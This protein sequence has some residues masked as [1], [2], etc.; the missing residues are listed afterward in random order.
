[1]DQKLW[2]KVVAFHGHECP[3]LAIGFRACEAAAKKMGIGNASDEELVCVTENDACG[4]DAVQV[5]FGCTFGKGNL[6]YRPRG[7]Q[8]FSFFN[9]QNGQKLRI[10]F[11]AKNGAAEIKDMLK[12][13]Q[14]ILNAPLDELFSFGEPRYE[15]PTR[16]KI[17]PT[18]I[19]EV[20]GEGAAEY[21]MHLQNGKTV[22][23]DCFEPYDRRF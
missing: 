20:C 22:C 3:G 12:R 8:A 17:F 11:K 2:E 15:L 1:M 23:E 4:V 7:K 10:Y 16:A 13:Q 6:I 5:I 18:V 9:R 21:K 19:C 14:Y